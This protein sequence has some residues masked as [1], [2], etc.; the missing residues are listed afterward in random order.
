MYNE[1]SAQSSEIWIKQGIVLLMENRGRKIG[2][3]ALCTV[4]VLTGIIFTIP[5]NTV[6]YEVMETYYDTEIRQEPYI[7]KEPYSSKELVDKQETI[8]NDTPY[9]VPYGV[10]VPLSITKSKVE[11]VGHFELPGSGGI[12][13]HVPSGQILY[14]QLGQ[15]G[16]FQISLAKGEYTAVLR[17][18]MVWGK[19]VRLTLT[20]KWTELEEVTKYRE[21]TK[22]R[23]VPVQVEK[24][25]SVTKYRKAS[26][27]ELIFGTSPR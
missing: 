21:V 18:S 11:L 1:F 15:R 22:T 24:Q 7:A 19:P 9:S 6:S 13:I 25:R 17:D 3:I 5:F 16:D 20:V 14:E 26:L 2:I 10:T 27:W 8:F 23:E 4:I 12:R